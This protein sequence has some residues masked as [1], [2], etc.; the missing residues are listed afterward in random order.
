MR[1]MIIGIRTTNNGLLYITESV[2]P[3]HLE[4]QGRLNAQLQAQ[5]GH[6]SPPIARSRIVSE[7]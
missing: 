1:L 4:P 2:T 7:Y 3:G 6:E 5:A